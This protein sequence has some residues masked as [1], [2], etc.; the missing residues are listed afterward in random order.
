M[1]NTPLSISESTFSN[2]SNTVFHSKESTKISNISQSTFRNGKRAL[3]IEDSYFSITQTL[4]SNF[5]EYDTPGGAIFPTSSFRLNI[6]NS[7]FS[8]NKGL[9][10]GAI[11]IDCLQTLSKCL[12]TIEDSYFDSNIAIFKGGAIY[13]S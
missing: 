11:F 8:K 5:G 3:I 10:G 9:D 12:V 7:T 1:V 6:S 4:F 2:F 13:Y